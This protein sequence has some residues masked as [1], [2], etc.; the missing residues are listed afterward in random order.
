[1]LAQTLTDPTIL[2][3]LYDEHLLTGLPDERLAVTL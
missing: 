3:H 2:E 1:M